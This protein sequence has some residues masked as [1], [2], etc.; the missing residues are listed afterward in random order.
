MKTLVWEPY[1][2]C[3]GRG[4]YE[5]TGRYRHEVAFDGD[6]IYILGGG[7]AEEVFDFI[8]IPM[9]DLEMKKWHK[10]RTKRDPRG[11]TFYFDSLS[12]FE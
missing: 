1:Y 8:D 6:C 11:M 12:E 4:D 9:F 7:T 3:Q 5:P 10:R 2:L